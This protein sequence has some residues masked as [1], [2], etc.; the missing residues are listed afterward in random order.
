MLLDYKV[1]MLSDGNATFTDEEHAG[2]LNSF[3]MFFD[4]SGWCTASA[5]MP[6]HGKRG[7]RSANGSRAAMLW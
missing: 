5:T 1:I 2:E 3:M 4:D 7:S 6:C